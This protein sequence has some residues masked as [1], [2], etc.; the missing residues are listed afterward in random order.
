MGAGRS[1]ENRDLR[2]HHSVSPGRQP[3][4]R[5]EQCAQGPQVRARHRSCPAQPSP[6]L[7]PLTLGFAA[8]LLFVKGREG[9]KVAP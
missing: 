7:P 3:R 8:V 9:V 4:P 5:P 6:A 2:G 1:D